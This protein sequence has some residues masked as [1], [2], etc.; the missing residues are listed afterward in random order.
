MLRTS[1][2]GAGTSTAAI[3]SLA[4]S[5]RLP[6]ARQRRLDQLLDKGREASLSAKESAELEAMLDGIDRKSFW[7]VARALVE[8]RNA[9]ATQTAVRKTRNGERE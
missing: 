3:R 7:M 6:A 2:L 1:T 8:K 5:P 9:S 4:K